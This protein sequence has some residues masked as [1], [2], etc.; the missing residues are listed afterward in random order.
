MLN[1]QVN[2]NKRIVVSVI[3]REKGEESER[4]VL[5]RERERETER[6]RVIDTFRDT[7]PIKKFFNFLKK[8]KKIKKKMEKLAN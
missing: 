4:E 7:L 6:V 3:D 5:E 8:K 2:M 1:E